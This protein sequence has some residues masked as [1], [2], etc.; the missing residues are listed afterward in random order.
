LR[1][2]T[3]QIDLSAISSLLGSTT[4]VTDA[5]PDFHTAAHTA[6]GLASRNLSISVALTGVILL[7]VCLLTFLRPRQWLIA[8][9]QAGRYYSERS[10]EKSRL[11]D[12]RADAARLA[13]AAQDSTAPPTD[14]EYD[15]LTDD[16]AKLPLKKRGRAQTPYREL[17]E[18]EA[19]EFETAQ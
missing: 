19:M 8:I 7:Q 12:E 4:K 5:G 2:Q 6:R 9:L 18:G 10:Y 15:S 3:D 17:S 16:P 14:S 1:A 11:S 13:Q